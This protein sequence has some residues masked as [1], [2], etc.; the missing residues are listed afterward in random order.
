[1]SCV[2][3]NQISDHGLNNDCTITAYRAK[4]PRD[5]VADTANLIERKVYDD[6]FKETLLLD[7]ADALICN[8]ID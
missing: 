1:M 6:L 5:A 7:L 4:K 8:Y 3:D 2:T